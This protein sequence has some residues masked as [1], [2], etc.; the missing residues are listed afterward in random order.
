MTAVVQVS[1]D[2]IAPPR[3]LAVWREALFQTEF[4]VDI[5]PISDTPFRAQ[6]KVR[7]L[8]GL[9]LVT[10]RSSPAHYRRHSKRVIR[11]DVVLSFGNEAHVTA[12][13]NGREA[14]METGDAFVLPCGDCASIQVSYGGPFTNVRLPRAALASNVTNLSDAYC[15]RISR[16]TP[17]LVLLKRYLS[18][19]N[20]EA[21]ALVDPTLQHSAVTH[22]YDLLAKTLG[23][24]REV[25]ALADRRGMRAARLAAI[26]DDIARHL[27]HARLSVHTV[28]SSHKVS[29]R[30]VQRLFDESGSTFTEY[31]VAQRLERA[32]RL[33]SDPRL[34]ARTL[35]A[36]AFAAGFNDL[37]HFQR[38]FRSRYGAAPSELRA[39]ARAEASGPVSDRYR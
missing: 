33:L 13:F 26:K 7:T 5:E 14:I 9:R 37:S 11:D 20:D 24:T 10:G 39:A 23:A 3:R 17:A 21:A 34:S 36:I 31:V 18:L 35:T 22:V 28:A 27:T 29:P 25:G 30:Y 6:A 4:N 38:R 16:D 8:S 2:D 1:T 32:R 19:L 15:R 12:R